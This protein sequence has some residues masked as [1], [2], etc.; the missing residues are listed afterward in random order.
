MQNNKQ[1]FKSR[2]EAKRQTGL[3]YIGGCNISSKMIKNTK[4][5]VLTYVIYLAPADMSGFNVCPKATADCKK[6]C[7]NGSGHN[8]IDVRNIINACRIKKT[9]LFFSDRAFY[10][11]WVYAEI[12]AYR[13]MAKRKGMEFS[14]RLNGT[15]DINPLLYK[16]NGLTLFELFPDVQFYDYTKVLNHTRICNRFKN[17]DLTFSYSGYNWNECL[18][19]LNMGVRVSVVFEDKL[20]ATYKGFKVID[21]DYTDLRY[22]DEPNVICG[23]KFKKV[24][25]KINFKKQKFV[26]PASDKDCVFK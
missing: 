4:K 6:A 16:H 15:S 7:L 11:S 18:E 17:Y 20:P 3:T 24:R 22:M 21:G 5:N 9:Q 13:D 25:T 8:R 14:I 19:A 26:V 1:I 23:L 10:M 2:G 12:S